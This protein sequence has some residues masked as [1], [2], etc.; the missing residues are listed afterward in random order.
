[1]AGYYSVIAFYDEN[2]IL[3]DSVEVK[4]SN[5]SAEITDLQITPPA[6]CTTN[7]GIIQVT[8]PVPPPYSVFNSRLNR[9]TSFSD[10]P[11]V[12]NNAD[13]G[14]YRLEISSGNCKLHVPI[15][16]P[17]PDV[18]FIMTTDPTCIGNDGTA[19]VISPN[20]PELTARFQPQ[21]SARDD[22]CLLYTSPSPRDATLSRMPSS[23]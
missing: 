10:N 23:A 3:T 14:S 22:R 17:R 9:T 21:N 13:E 1:M 12:Y 18:P 5:E 15:D 16:V 11:F 8:M 2:C 4:I 6:G 19:Q 20:A 7:D